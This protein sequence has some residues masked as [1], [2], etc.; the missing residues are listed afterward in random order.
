MRSP[1]RSTL[2]LA[3]LLLIGTVSVRADVLSDAK[4]TAANVGSAVASGASNAAS[5]VGSWVTSAWGSTS[6][7][8]TVREKKVLCCAGVDGCNITAALPSIVPHKAPPSPPMPQDTFCKAQNW[9]K[10]FDPTPCEEEGA[11]N[12]TNLCPESC[13]NQLSK[14]GGT[15]QGKLLD[16]LS[17][18]DKTDA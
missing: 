15:C 12:S 17:G 5:S 6:S 10:G 3:L 8:A 7:F 9:F 11:A 2:L 13:K 1:T 16:S 4:D 18:Q 14:L